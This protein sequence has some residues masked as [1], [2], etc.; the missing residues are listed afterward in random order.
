MYTQVI[1]FCVLIC[2][3]AF[4]HITVAQKGRISVNAGVTLDQDHTPLAVSVE[5]FLSDGI[6]IQG[7]RSQVST[8]T[9]SIIGGSTLSMSSNYTSTFI[10][11]M[12][13]FHASTF[14]P[15]DYQRLDPYFGLLVG[16]ILLNGEVNINL[17]AF[18]G[19][20]TAKESRTYDRVTICVPIGIR[21]SINKQIGAFVEYNAGIANTT[22]DI[23]RNGKQDKFYEKRQYQLGVGMSLRF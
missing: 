10:G 9:S 12:A 11:L 19:Q 6:G 2:T 3:L 18:G 22:A 14:L 23:D 1:S 7:Y 17:G 20:S 5:Y 4:S 15:E 13:N 8:S 16:K 21:Y